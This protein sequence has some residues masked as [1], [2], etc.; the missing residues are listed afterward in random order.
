MAIHCRT[1]RLEEPVP[2][3]NRDW[4]FCGHPVVLQSLRESGFLIGAALLNLQFSFY[5]E[6]TGNLHPA[7]WTGNRFK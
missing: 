3:A 4:F 6:L 5:F 7:A 2:G 1:S